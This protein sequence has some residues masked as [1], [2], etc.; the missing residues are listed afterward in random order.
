M[1][2]A[3]FKF[4]C[5]DSDDSINNFIHLLIENEYI[6]HIDNRRKKDHG[7]VIVTVELEDDNK[8]CSQCESSSYTVFDGALMLFCKKSQEYKNIYQRCDN[9][10]YD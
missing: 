8:L 7:E 2:S 1:I 10:E 4:R 9:F 6:V 5:K 3:R